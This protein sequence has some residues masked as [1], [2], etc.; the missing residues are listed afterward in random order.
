MHPNIVILNYQTGNIHS[1]KRKIE[2]MGIEPVISSNASDVLKAD[3]IILPGVGHFAEAMKNL[4]KLNLIDALHEA[5]LI[6]KKP[7]L[8]ICLGMQLMAKTSEEGFVNGLGW[9]NAEI[10]RFNIDD[11][12]K[13]KV[14]HVGWNQIKIKKESVLM[15]GVPDLTE[16]YF[17]HSFYCKCNEQKDILTETDYE[18]NFTS[19]I[20]KDNIFG[21]QYHPEKSHDTGE[22]LI[23][24]FVTNNV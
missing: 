8:G 18:L 3:K 22:I 24:N 17:V 23:K 10:M 16:F 14:P 12:F 15:N 20:E 19:A 21:V 9:I 1:I 13:F 4:I 2:R 5:V 7:I 11:K 6:K